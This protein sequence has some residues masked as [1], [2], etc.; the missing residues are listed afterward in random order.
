MRR[1]DHS[2]RK[3]NREKEKRQTESR[4]RTATGNKRLQNKANPTF[5]VADAPRW[6]KSRAEHELIGS[7]AGALFR[8]ASQRLVFGGSCSVFECSYAY[9]LPRKESRETGRTHSAGL[10]NAAISKGRDPRMCSQGRRAGFCFSPFL[11]FSFSLFLFFSFSL[12]LP[13]HL[14]RCNLCWT[15]YSQDT[16]TQHLT[17]G[18]S[19]TSVNQEERPSWQCCPPEESREETREQ[20]KANSGEVISALSRW[21]EQGMGV[22]QRRGFLSSYC[23]A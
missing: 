10:L 3:K 19:G 2:L 22:A 7:P 6:A 15:M 4:G 16:S 9:R 11:L 18:A 12:F 13:L 23:V 21:F 5:A 1:V 8:C 17:L 14:L 20:E